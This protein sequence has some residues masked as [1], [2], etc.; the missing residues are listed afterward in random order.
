MTDTFKKITI[1]SVA[2][3]TLGATVAATTTSADAQG[4]RRGY[5]GNGYHRSGIGRG[6]AI[7]LGLAA[8]ALATGAAYNYD[9]RPYGY[10]YG[11]GYYGRPY[12]Y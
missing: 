4:F 3:L 7:G 6:A 9:H 8:G 11:D 12:G 1:A 2:A 10:G 5:Y